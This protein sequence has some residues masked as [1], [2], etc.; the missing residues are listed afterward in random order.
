M[1]LESFDGWTRNLILLKTGEVMASVKIGDYVNL[2]DGVHE[3]WDD[4][5]GNSL[6][7][8]QM[9]KFGGQGG[10]THEDRRYMMMLP[11]SG[12]NL[13][14]PSTTVIYK[15]I[16]IKDGIPIL[17][18]QA[19]YSSIKALKVNLMDYLV[20]DVFYH[21]DDIYMSTDEET[22]AF[23]LKVIDSIIVHDPNFV[24]SI[25]L[26][27]EFVP[28]ESGANDFLEFKKQIRAMAYNSIRAV[29]GRKAA[30]TRKANKLID[31]EMKSFLKQLA[32]TD[33]DFY[34]QVR[35]K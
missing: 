7:S 27:R 21:L 6:Y 11:N 1:D 32:L 22:K 8:I 9:Q 10:I 12:R 18:R 23:K 4:S 31:E 24:D 5:T 13:V 17:E 26:D 35:G 29:A 25:L 3:D 30:E 19:P 16:E 14:I 28:Y 2:I 20:E 33:D 15:V 34:D